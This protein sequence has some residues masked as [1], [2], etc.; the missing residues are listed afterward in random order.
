MLTKDCIDEIKPLFD[1]VIRYNTHVDGEYDS[2]PILQQWWENK[3]QLITALGDTLIYE[4]PSKITFELDKKEKKNQYFAFCEEIEKY[5]NNDLLNFVSWCGTDYFYKNKI[6]EPYDQNGYFIPRGVKVIK[7]FKFFEQDPVILDEIQTKASRT[8]QKN[9]ITGTMCLSVHPLDFL[10]S[11]E[12]THNWRS[13]HSL[14]GDYRAG[15]L[16][17][18]T[19]QTTVICYLRSDDLA[20][21]PGFPDDVPWTNK[22]WRMLLTVDTKNFRALFAGRQYPFF[23]KAALDTILQTIRKLPFFRGNWSNWH[24]DYLTKQFSYQ[25]PEPFERYDYG[26][27]PFAMGRYYYILE[28]F[29]QNDPSELHFNDLLR[30]S[31]YTPYYC[32]RDSMSLG[33]IQPIKIG[34]SPTC[35]VCGKDKIIN[36]DE[37]TCSWCAT[38][39]KTTKIGECVVCGRTVENDENYSHIAMDLVCENCY[40]QHVHKCNKCHQELIYWDLLYNRDT[41]DYTCAYCAMQ[42]R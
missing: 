40:N 5:E 33:P 36:T 3:Q 20:V 42:R 29:I 26:N 9:K 12:N 24:N 39:A 28:N 22:K 17:Y 7:A 19:D 15:N 16:S 27:R 11:S 35:P 2:V 13:C 23:S 4:L 32:W 21:L 37:L 18:M 34:W 6:D 41:H 10:S 14:D 1:K 30:S 31:V 38:C 25:E 8:I